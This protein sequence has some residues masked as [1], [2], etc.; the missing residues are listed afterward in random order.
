VATFKGKTSDAQSPLLGA[1]FWK[2]G[3]RIEGVI[4][5][6]FSMQ[7]GPGYEISLRTPVKV[8]GAMEKK[9]S[10]GALKGLKMALNAAGVEDWQVG[11]K[12]VIECTGSTKTTKG[13]DRVDFAIA[14]DRPE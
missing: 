1:D 10:I 14:L 7:T 2:K 4:Q 8:A 6:E 11:D 3:V 13:N 9:V 5:R 12:V